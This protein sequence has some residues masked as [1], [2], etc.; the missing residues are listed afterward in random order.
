MGQQM[1]QFK[2][3]SSRKV[4][5]WRT[6]TPG[7]AE[8]HDCGCQRAQDRNSVGKCWHC[9]PVQGFEGLKHW[10]F[11]WLPNQSWGQPLYCLKQ[12]QCPL[13]STQSLSASLPRAPS[14]LFT[15]VAATLREWWLGEGPRFPCQQGAPELY[16]GMPGNFGEGRKSNLCGS[17]GYR[18]PS[19]HSTSPIG[20]LAPGFS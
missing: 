16:A 15:T 7:K 6:Q 12:S 4:V 18:G 13:F 3:D 10:H 14:L 20:E 9:C 11:V 5:N 2:V 1:A 8:K 19:L 17:A